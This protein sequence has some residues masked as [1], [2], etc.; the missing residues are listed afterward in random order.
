MGRPEYRSIG[1]TARIVVAGFSMSGSTSLLLLLMLL[2]RRRDADQSILLRVARDT[3]IFTTRNMSGIVQ[4]R[5]RGNRSVEPGYHRQRQPESDIDQGLVSR[6]RSRTKLTQRMTICF[7]P[8]TLDGAA[9]SK[10][11]PG[12]VLVDGRLDP[13]CKPTT[14]PL[15]IKSPGNDRA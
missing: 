7:L 2:L 3:S 4:S 12:L 13:A 1:L 9:R 15:R 5:R 11:D 8:R 10:R 6:I 14:M